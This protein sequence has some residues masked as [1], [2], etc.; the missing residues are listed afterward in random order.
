MT[1][2]NSLE[3]LRQSFQNLLPPKDERMTISPLEFIVILIFHYLGDSK[4][5]SMES[6]R[7]SMKGYLGK[8]IERS[9]FWERL[10]GNRLKKDLQAI[11]ANLMESFNSSLSLGKEIL[12][13]LNVSSILVIDSST[14][15]LINS[16]KN[17][18]WH[19]FTSRD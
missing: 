2:N 11:V 18:F 17:F 1:E 8:G 5:S 7:K 3:I 15:T 16:A 12:I 19:R 6:I 9:S 14:I 4:T 13:V 10:A